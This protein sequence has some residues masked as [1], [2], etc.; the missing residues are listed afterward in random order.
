[1]ELVSRMMDGSMGFPGGVAPPESVPE[2]AIDHGARV[3][4]LERVPIFEG[5]TGAEDRKSVV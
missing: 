5:L 2:P 4:H 1:M 3:K